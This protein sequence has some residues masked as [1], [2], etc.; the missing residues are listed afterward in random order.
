[1]ANRA[2]PGGPSRLTNTRTTYAASRTPSA[3]Q[4]RRK[5][6][7]R[8]PLGSTKIGVPDP[9]VCTKILP[10]RHGPGLHRRGSIARYSTRS[11]AA[12][13][14]PGSP[15]TVCGR[16]FTKPA[17]LGWGCVTP[18]FTPTARPLFTAARSRLPEST[19]GREAILRFHI[20]AISSGLAGYSDPGTGLFVL[21]AAWLAAQGTCCDSG[22]RHYPYVDD[23]VTPP[24]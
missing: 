19:R 23:E 6:P 15:W 21:T 24:T 17:G 14:S 16:P 7:R 4:A 11:P 10:P 8:R 12:S 13:A 20:A 2:N 9:A 1:M 3:Q 5:I 18:R 22:C